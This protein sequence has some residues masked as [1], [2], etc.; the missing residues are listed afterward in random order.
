[1]IITK[2]ITKNLWENPL[3]VWLTSED[4]KVLEKDTRKISDLFKIIAPK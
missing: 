4:N 2:Q 1:M 3:Y